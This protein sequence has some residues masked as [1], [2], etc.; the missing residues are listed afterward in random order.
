[1]VCVRVQPRRAPSLCVRL[2]AAYIRLRTCHSGLFSAQQAPSDNLSLCPLLLITTEPNHTM[3]DPTFDCFFS[4]TINTSTMTATPLSPPRTDA[5]PATIKMEQLEVFDASSPRESVMS[6]AEPSSTPASS[7]STTDAKSVKKRKS[8]G[9]VLPEPK[10]SLPPRK[11]A[12]TEDEKEQRRIER[13]KRNRLAAHNSRERKRQEYEVLQDQKDRMELEVKRCQLQMAQMRAELMFYRQKYPGEAPSTV[14]DLS[15]PATTNST[16]DDV[17]T[18][19][20]AQTSTQLTSPMS[21]SMDSFDS[22]R[23]DSYQPETPPSNFEAHPEFDS[24]Q[25]SAAVLCDLQCQSISGAASP[26]LAAILAYLTLFHLTLPSMRSLLS[27]TTSSPSTRSPKA[28]LWQQ[29]A[30]WN[31]LWAWLI[32]QA[33]SL[34][35]PSTATTPSPPLMD[36]P[37]ALMQSSL[38]CRVPLARLWSATGLSQRR[39]S[40]DDMIAKPHEVTNGVGFVDGVPGVRRVKSTQ[41]RQLGWR[42]HAGLL[43]QE[44][45]ARSHSVSQRALRAAG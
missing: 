34:V 44:P 7:S 19:C 26:S 40:V 42:K 33:T 37:M 10:T 17:A 20:P 22:P 15:T 3:G 8:W 32:L 6:I 24:T 14:F 38:I 36:L 45:W 5:V 2:A 31:P 30:P 39:T 28:P 12:K 1:V 29:L 41:H 35:R 13:V 11:R 21:M 43:G 25:Y 18:I 23:E 4:K 27:W 9:Q 16:T